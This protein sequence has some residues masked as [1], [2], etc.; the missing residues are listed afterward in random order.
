MSG[1]LTLYT[2]GAM[3]GHH[4]HNREAFRALATQLRALGHTAVSPVELDERDGIDFTR[5][6]TPDEYARCLGRDIELIG[7]M[8]ARGELDGGVALDGWEASRGAQAEA[9]VILALGRPIYRLVEEGDGRALRV[10]REPTPARHPSSARYHRILHDLGALH[11]LKSQDY[12][13]ESDPFANVRA[14]SEWGVPEWVGGM[15]RA[16]D[17][18]K[19]LQ[20]FARKGVLANES[21]RDAFLDLA[22]YAVISLI[23]YDEAE[24]GL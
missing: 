20:T 14:S 18:V 5:A 16:T 7:G 22:V 17:K 10:I 6:L 15:I 13:S 4:D 23:L 21:A 8:L 9:T 2:L 19:R 11:D 12:G 3:T 1:S 24:A